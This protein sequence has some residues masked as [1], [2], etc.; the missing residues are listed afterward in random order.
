MNAAN[1][2]G[3]H[4]S[5][6]PR[7][8]RP[9]WRRPR[10]PGV[11][12]RVLLHLLVGALTLVSA[13]A[14]FKPSSRS[15]ESAMTVSAAHAEQQS[16]GPTTVVAP[17]LSATGAAPAQEPR[18]ASAGSA[19]ITDL[20]ST[21]GRTSAPAVAAWRGI[22][23]VEVHRRAAPNRLQPPVGE[24]KAGTPV[25]VVDWVSGE[26][27][28]S[29][30]NTWAKLSDGTYVFST[31]LR[32]NPVGAPPELPADAPMAGR[33]VDVNLSAQVATAYDGRA[34]LRSALISSGRPGWETPTGVFPVLRRIEKD[35]MDGA[36][37]V[38]QGPNGAG[39]TYK[40]ENVRYV[41]YFTADG[42]AVHENYW[43][44][45]ATF[46]MPGSHGCIGMAPADAAW[47]WEFAAVGTPLVI[48]E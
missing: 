2:M 9:V 46:G 19:T 1:L 12:P 18:L 13:Q 14:L 6:R 40:V 47:F 21:I 29:H 16:P 25:E 24:L 15:W 37:L 48:H 38:G 36:S 42:A 3:C 32:R 39:A 43:R 17:S 7:Q 4:A 35:T 30:N 41:Q 5:A 20:S 27:V 28:E 26:E 31:S 11:T 22:A 8:A 44:R 23:G 10:R 34:A 33:W 45:P